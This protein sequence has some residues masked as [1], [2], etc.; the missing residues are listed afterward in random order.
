MRCKRCQKEFPHRTGTY[1]GGCQVEPE[2]CVKCEPLRAEVARL[3]IENRNQANDLKNKTQIIQEQRVLLEKRDA[4][5][6]LL[7]RELSDR[8]KALEIAR[9]EIGRLGYDLD[10]AHQQVN[11]LYERGQKLEAENAELR[12]QY[13]QH[14]YQAQR[15]MGHEWGCPTATTPGAKCDCK[16]EGGS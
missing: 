14:F 7:K 11:R 4:R 12:R 6:D 10:E 5:I 3:R 9:I 16:Q 13:D 8:D 2:S 15:A 1:C